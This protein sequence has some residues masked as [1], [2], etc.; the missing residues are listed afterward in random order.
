MGSYPNSTLTL[1][2]L[3]LSL[4]KLISQF[5]M[6]SKTISLKCGV[7][8]TV[9]TLQEG[10]DTPPSTPATPKRESAYSKASRA[11][12]LVIDELSLMDIIGTK[13]ML[14]NEKGFIRDVR[15]NEM[16]ELFLFQAE[17]S[18]DSKWTFK[19][20]LQTL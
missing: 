11:S 9:H 19:W 6:S 4:V 14:G 17:G 15:K 8:L 16:G 3:R 5:T 2:T 20:L 7:K 18:Q 1:S 12:S 13:V 10:Q